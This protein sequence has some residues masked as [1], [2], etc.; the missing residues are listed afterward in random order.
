MRRDEL[1]LA[2][3][4]LG[5]ARCR[6]KVEESQEGEGDGRKKREQQQEQYIGDAKAAK[7]PFFKGATAGRGLSTP[8][9]ASHVAMGGG[10]GSDPRGGGWSSPCPLGREAVEGER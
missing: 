10:G 4:A 5:D 7:T 6:R 9:H 1:D 8:L 3:L 2:L